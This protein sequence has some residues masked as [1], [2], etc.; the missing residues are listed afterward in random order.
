MTLPPA[1]VKRFR[2]RGIPNGSCFY[3]DLS[4]IRHENMPPIPFGE[5][6][7]YA[8]WFWFRGFAAFCSA[9]LQQEAFLISQGPFSLGIHRVTRT[10]FCRAEMDGPQRRP[11][12]GWSIRGLQLPRDFG[13]FCMELF[14]CQQ[15]L[16]QNKQKTSPFG[17][18]MYFFI[19]VHRVRVSESP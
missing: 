1:S 12:R 4:R 10:P 18:S 19:N 7:H 13:C 5:H 8:R 16:H 2:S 17:L 9:F 15:Y 6:S 3:S 11:R 14:L